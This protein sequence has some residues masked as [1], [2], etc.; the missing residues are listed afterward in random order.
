[1]L[2]FNRLTPIERKQHMSQKPEPTSPPPEVFNPASSGV[3]SPAS[4]GGGPLLPVKRINLEGLR[5][6][7][8]SILSFLHINHKRSAYWNAVCD[9]GTKRKVC[10]YELTSGGSK[11][12]GCY[13]RERVSSVL[14]NNLSG[15]KF[16]RLLVV[17]FHHVDEWR[18]AHWN[19]VCD[20]GNKR[21]VCGQSLKTG[22]TTSCGCFAHEF[23]ASKVGEKH[24]CW[25]PTLT[26]EDR[27]RWR[28]GTPTQVTWQK[29]AQRIR[30]RDRFTCAVCGAR[31]LSVHHINPWALSK[32]HRFNPSNLI[33]LCKS[34]H[35]Q[36]HYIYGH[37]CDLND[38]E[39]YL[40]E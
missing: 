31:G 4:T 22:G 14:R 26:K 19:V 2:S 17:S 21:V 12:C 9:C 3:A 29:L 27:E 7:R 13:Q 18:A 6:G 30:I 28:L 16:G 36:F 10:G 33:T 39:E 23:L 24:H 32:C 25:K 1:M 8:W 34:C 37:D 11:S 35:K 15:K 20:C 38:L 5:F 40:Y